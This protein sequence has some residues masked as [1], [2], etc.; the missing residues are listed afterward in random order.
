[1]F[2]DNPSNQLDGGSHDDGVIEGV[3]VFSDNHNERLFEGLDIRYAGVKVRE[4][5]ANE[6]IE[7]SEIAEV[8][9]DPTAYVFLRVDDGKYKVVTADWYF[10]I[11]PELTKIIH[12]DHRDNDLLGP[13]VRKFEDMRDGSATPRRARRRA[14]G[15]TKKFLRNIPVNSKEYVALLREF[16]FEVDTSGKGHY[17]ITHPD[18]PHEVM[19]MP[20][21][22]SDV[23]WSLNSAA[24][25]RRVFGIDLRRDDPDDCIDC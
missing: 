2:S 7:L 3:S 23:Y 24:D 20:A 1:M 8:L 14:G 25:I 16:G 22:P 19:P 17:K 12:M 13:W 10:I 15:G 4:F 9:S 18:V 11:S 5:L 21:T 6:G